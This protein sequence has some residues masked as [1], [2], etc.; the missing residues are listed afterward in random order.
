MATPKMLSQ[1]TQLGK[2]GFN[3]EMQFVDECGK[4]ALGTGFF[5]SFEELGLADLININLPG[6]LIQLVFS[7]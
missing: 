6:T 4:V 1:S 7:A 3:I 2:L 5:K